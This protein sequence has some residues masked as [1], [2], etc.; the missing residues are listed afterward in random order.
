MESK[1]TSPK[2]GLSIREQAKAAVKNFRQSWVLVGQL[3]LDIAFGGDYREWGFDNFEQYCEEELKI[4]RRQVKKLM[5]SYQYLK[6]EKPQQLR[7]ILNGDDVPCPGYEVINDMRSAQGMAKTV[8]N[9]DQDAIKEVETKLFD[10]EISGREATQKIREAHIAAEDINPPDPTIKQLAKITASYR[11]L[12]K[13][14]ANN[15]RIPEE[16]AELMSKVLKKL[17]ELAGE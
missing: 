10:G 15:E 14:V 11:K 17:Q 13:E 3:L 12:C 2:K 16:V 6:Q 8:G 9:Y 7:A 1:E 5:N 4:R